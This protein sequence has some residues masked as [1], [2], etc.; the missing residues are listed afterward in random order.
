[1]TKTELIEIIQNGGNSSVEFK[2]DDVENFKVAK[3]IVALLNLQGGIILFGVNDDGSIRGT[4]RD[5]LEDW[6]I[7]ICRVKL[8]PPIVPHLA[9]IRDFEPN[10]D[11]LVVRFPVGLDKP[12]SRFHNNRHTYYIRIGTN[13][14]EASRDELER[15]FQASGRL[16]YGRKPV[17]GTLF[18]DLDIRRLKQYFGRVLK[19]TIYADSDISKWNSLLINFD[20]MIAS[21]DLVTA[22]VD[23][24]LLFGK[25]PKR[26]LPQSGI[27]AIVYPGSSP[28]YETITDQ[29]LKG[30]M[31]PLFSQDKNLLESGLVEQAIDFIKRNTGRNSRL[32]DGSRR[33]DRMDYPEE[34]IREVIVNALVH[35]DYSIAGTDIFI[36]IFS[37]RIVVKSPGR[38]P[39]TATIEA[40]KNGFRFARNQSLVNVMRDYNYVEFRGMGIKEKIIPGMQAHNGTEPEFFEDE[41]SFTVILFQVSTLGGLYELSH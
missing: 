31:T 29:E 33:S 4:T 21:E 7:E 12:Y 38:L 1:M 39:N 6:I 37:N 19:S 13:S 23:G 41:H 32:E 25:N 17:P 11:I 24:I 34:V 3:E 2:L 30:P 10:K 16:N 40:L 22:S 5:D 26:Y 36:T 9:W 28:N 18:D 35:R 27:R 15:M 14:R 8:K 20:F